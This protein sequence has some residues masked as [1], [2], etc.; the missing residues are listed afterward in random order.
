MLSWIKRI[1][2]IS[3]PCFL[4]WIA[5]HS[6]LSSH[7]MLQNLLCHPELYTQKYK[8][9]QTHYVWLY[10]LK[11]QF[12]LQCLGWCWIPPCHGLLLQFWCSL[13]HP[14]FCCVFQFGLNYHFLIPPHKKMQCTFFM[15]GFMHLSISLFLSQY[16]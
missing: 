4:F 13:S 7:N 12:E 16:F 6:F 8:S 1:P 10:R 9:N 3:M 15:L 2:L 5:R 11:Y 14:C